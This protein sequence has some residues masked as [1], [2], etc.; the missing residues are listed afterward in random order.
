M[1]LTHKLR[2]EAYELRHRKGRRRK[3]EMVSNMNT[4][5]AIYIYLYLFFCLYGIT[6]LEDINYGLKA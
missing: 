1:A 5:I 6:I 4:I 3:G 2:V